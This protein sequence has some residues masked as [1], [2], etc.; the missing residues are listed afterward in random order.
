MQGSPEELEVL[1]A[2]LRQAVEPLSGKEKGKL[3]AG[4]AGKYGD[5]H[6]AP[7]DELVSLVR[8][9]H[10]E[11][12]KSQESFVKHG[13]HLSNNLAYEDQER[14]AGEIVDHLETAGKL[15]SGTML[16]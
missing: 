1:S 14:I 5:A 8:L 15:G 11:A 2:S 13:P 12:A 7:W 9:V 10:R 6:R 16:T 4:Y 3:A